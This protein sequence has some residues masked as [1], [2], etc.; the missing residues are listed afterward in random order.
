VKYPTPHRSLNPRLN[1]FFQCTHSTPHTSCTSTVPLYLLQIDTEHIALGISFW[2]RNT[3]PPVILSIPV[4][5]T[6]SN[7]QA[8]PH[9][10][11][12]RPP[13]L[14]LYSRPIL[15]LLPSVSVF[16]GDIPRPPFFSQSPAPALSPMHT[17]YPTCIL[18]TPCASFPTPDRYQVR[19]APYSLLGVK[20]IHPH[21]SLDPR[22]HRFR[23]CTRLTPHTPYT[24]TVPLFLL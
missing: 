9:T 15:S 7:A 2:W 12:T 22:P 21:R 1:H 10:H 14:F 4:S 13:S 23:K 19:Y 24:P 8:A 18:H 11:P 6:F 3:P 17:R 20:S 5:T 16:G